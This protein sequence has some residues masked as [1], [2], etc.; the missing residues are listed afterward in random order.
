MAGAD[1]STHQKGRPRLKR[2]DV[3][4]AK[5]EEWPVEGLPAERVEGAARFLRRGRRLKVTL[6]PDSTML[7]TLNGAPLFELR[8]LSAGDV[9]NAGVALFVFLDGHDAREPELEALVRDGPETSEARLVYA[10][11]LLER[12]DPLGAHVAQRGRRAPKRGSGLYEGL[13]PDVVGGALHLDWRDG[14]L[15]AA[16]LRADGASHHWTHLLAQ[17]CSLRAAFSLRELVLDFPALAQRAMRPLTAEQLE[18]GLDR[19]VRLLSRSAVGATL[20]RLVLGYHLAPTEEL[21]ALVAKASERWRQQLPRLGP[22]PLFHF[23]PVAELVVEAAPP[24]LAGRVGNRTLVRQ[25]LVF[26][27]P[28]RPTD[29]PWRLLPRPEPRPEVPYVRASQGRWVLGTPGD[30]HVVRINGV[31]VDHAVLL[32]GDRL[33]FPHGVV[34]RFELSPSGSS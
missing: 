12:G 30:E 13:W 34:A 29:W 8:S 4:T 17:L 23:R 9:V 32:P 11:W 25:G 14:Y 26:E 7:P 10:D 24:P 18:D 5:V 20:E 33:E 19:A 28:R 21:T 1:A 3:E 15:R 16:S 31:S 2:I 22:G 27:R 6:N